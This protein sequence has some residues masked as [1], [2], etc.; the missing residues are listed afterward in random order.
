MRA[1]LPSHWCEHRR[2]QW[3]EAQ[4]KRWLSCCQAGRRS[5]YRRMCSRVRD[6]DVAAR[7]VRFPAGEFL[8]ELF[9]VI[10]VIKPGKKLPVPEVRYIGECRTCECV[11]ECERGDGPPCM[12]SGTE[13]VNPV[14]I[15]GHR[16]WAISVKCPNDDCDG[17]IAC[18][19]QVVSQ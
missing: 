6:S 15:S 2:R 12:P 1:F 13:P 11:V 9:S 3:N 17:R 5:G 18:W 14:V 19:P 10:T 7:W 8:G 16:F 4:R